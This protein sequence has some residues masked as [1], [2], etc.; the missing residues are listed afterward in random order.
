MFLES[1]IVELER[2][3]ILGDISNK[4]VRCGRSSSHLHIQ[5]DLDIGALALTQQSDAWLRKH[6]NVVGQRT[7]W[8][9]RGTPA[10]R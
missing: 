1:I 6:L 9:L 8:E 3:A 10:S 4:F 2:S 5:I 7:A